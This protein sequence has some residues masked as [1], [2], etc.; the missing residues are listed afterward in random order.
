MTDV[1]AA[2]PRLVG[3]RTA[4]VLQPDER[5]FVHALVGNFSGGPQNWRE[6]LSGD[7]QAAVDAQWDSEWTEPLTE[8][9]MNIIKALLDAVIDTEH[10][11][12]LHTLTGFTI[13][14]ARWLR[15]KFSFK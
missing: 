8:E 2:P 10:T 12:E 13:D 4:Y 1:R 15:F 9:S 5:D 6:S 11:S 3:D 14:F 7:L